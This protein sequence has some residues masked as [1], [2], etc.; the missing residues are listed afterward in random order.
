MK[1]LLA[2]SLLTASALADVH[3]VVAF[4]FKADADPAKVKNIEKEFAALKQKIDV[5]QKLEWGTNVSKEG[6]NKGFN[7]CWILTF[8][9]EADRDAYIEHAAHKEFVK[10]LGGVLD[11]A[12]VIDFKPQS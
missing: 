1:F 6:H 10:L 8:K 4:K 7:H 3:H 12:F 9:N 5:V 11:D 2:L